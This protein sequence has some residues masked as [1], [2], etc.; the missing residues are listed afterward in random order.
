MYLEY[1]FKQCTY[2]YAHVCISEVNILIFPQCSMSYWLSFETGFLTEA[3]IKLDYPAGRY[4]SLPHSLSP[5]WRL[6]VD[7]AMPNFSYRCW[8]TEP[9]PHAP[10]VSMLHI[11]LW[12]PACLEHFWMSIWIF[13]GTPEKVS[14]KD[15]PCFLSFNIYIISICFA[16]IKTFL[17]K[18]CFSCNSYNIAVVKCNWGGGGDDIAFQQ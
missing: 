5:T 6:Q 18:T 17:F 14:C 13:L 15:I 1:S 4:V 8:E 10:A 16:F 2:K 3:L 7:T 11:P 9:G 12:F